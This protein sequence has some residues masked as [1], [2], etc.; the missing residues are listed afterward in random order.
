ML[1]ISERIVIGAPRKIE[2]KLSEEEFVIRAIGK[3]RGKHKGLHSV[4]SGFNDAFRGY[5]GTNPV[6][7]VQRL[8]QEKLQ[9]LFNKIFGNCYEPVRAKGIL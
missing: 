3:L 4:F 6:E 9:Y 7:T 8:G 2:P 1:F 5:F